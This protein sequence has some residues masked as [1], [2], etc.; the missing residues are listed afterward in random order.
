MRAPA[1]IKCIDDELRAVR[2]VALNRPPTTT[3]RSEFV[4]TKPA[5]IARDP[6]PVVVAAPVEPIDERTAVRDEVRA[7]KKALGLSYREFADA[8][9]VSASAVQ[10]WTNGRYRPTRDNLAEIRRLV[11]EANP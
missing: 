1:G 3:L 7:A 4:R 8:L 2:E 10:F 11:A 6:T 5:A 9:G